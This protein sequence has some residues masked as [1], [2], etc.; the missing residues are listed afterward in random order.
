MAQAALRMR[1]AAAGLALVMAALP[2]AAG[3]AVDAAAR[4]EALL[5]D[6]RPAEAIEAARDA[7]AAIWQAAPLAVLRA[8][9]VLGR[10]RGW[11]DYRPRGSTTYRPDE[12]IRLYVEPVGFGY[13]TTPGGHRR[14]RLGVD[15]R[16]L[17]PTRAVLAELPRIARLEAE[18]GDE[19]REFYG[20]LAYDLGPL[21]PG[22]YIL[23]TTL[24][25]LA[26]GERASFETAITIAR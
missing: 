2:A 7:L 5:A 17:A 20:E 10:V 11:R 26:S 8:E 19:T 6:G 18:A 3:P 16:I 21:P 1:A 15:L 22:S 12:I 9:P 4:A 13:L 25:D 14:I 24:R 23:E